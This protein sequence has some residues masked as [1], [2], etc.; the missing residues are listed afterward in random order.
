MQAVLHGAEGG[1][2]RKSRDFLR[3]TP[4]VKGGVLRRKVTVFQRNTCQASR[5][6]N[7][8]EKLVTMIL[9]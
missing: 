7:N 6:K 9:L 8:L 2:R 4:S 5:R 1:L 3:K